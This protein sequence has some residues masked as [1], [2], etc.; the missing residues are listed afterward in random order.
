[1][2]TSSTVYP[3]IELDTVHSPSLSALVTA[4]DTTNDKPIQNVF[5]RQSPSSLDIHY[6]YGPYQNNN[7]IHQSFHQNGSIYPPILLPTSNYHIGNNISG[8]YGMNTPIIQY[9]PNYY[10]N[11]Y[12][13]SSFSPNLFEHM[14]STFDNQHDLHSHGIITDDLDEKSSSFRRAQPRA[15]KRQIS[16]DFRGVSV[17]Q[18]HQWR[19]QIGY[20]GKRISV[21]IFQDEFEAARA[22]DLTAYALHG[23]LAILNFDHLTKEE[24]CYP[25]TVKAVM[26]AVSYAHSRQFQEKPTIKRSHHSILLPHQNMSMPSMKQEYI[27]SGFTS[28]PS[29]SSITHHNDNIGSNS[30]SVET[31]SRGRPRGKRVASFFTY[32][33]FVAIDPKEEEAKMKAEI[34]QLIDEEKINPGIRRSRRKRLS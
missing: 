2:N 11:G 18:N 29:K 6:K 7:F 5:H 4:I 15:S 31:R 28:I 24:D 10:Y 20:Q 32:E 25:S 30:I 3:G 17:T 26:A 27:S 16:S 12:I 19:V 8:S 9:I 13:P 14:S 34:Q 23:H 22:Y 1:M 33:P 21:G